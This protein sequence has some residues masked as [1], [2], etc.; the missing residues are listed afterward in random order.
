VSVA[1]AGLRETLLR[2][3]MGDHGI[4]PERAILIGTSALV[5]YAILS[6]VGIA[7]VWARRPLR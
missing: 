7:L 4:T 5:P 6:C 1:G 2:V 3:L